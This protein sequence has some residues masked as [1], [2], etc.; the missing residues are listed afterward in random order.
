MDSVWRYPAF[1]LQA[2]VELLH[3]AQGEKVVII[4]HSMGVNVW[5]YF[6]DWDTW[7]ETWFILM[8]KFDT[9]SIAFLFTVLSGISPRFRSH[10]WLIGDG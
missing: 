10:Q 3:E 1:V 4:A 7:I 9:F 8:D 6:M 5:F 2:E